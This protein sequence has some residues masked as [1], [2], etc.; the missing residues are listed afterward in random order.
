M[1]IFSEAMSRVEFKNKIKFELR[2]R[3]F[4]LRDQLNLTLSKIIELQI[5]RD[6]TYPYLGAVNITWNLDEFT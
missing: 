6:L 1:R 4:D 5:L 3:S 2:V